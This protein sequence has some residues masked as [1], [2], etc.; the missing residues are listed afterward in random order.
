VL[1][2]GVGGSCRGWLPL[3]VPEFSRERRTLI[4]DYPGV[5]ESEAVDAPFTTAD[6]ADTT[7]ALLDALGV[8]RADVLGSFMGGMVAQELAL[9]HPERVERLALVGTYARPDA[10][11]VTLLRQWQDLA[12]MNAP[13]EMFVRERILWTL[14]DE[15]LEQK[16]LIESMVDF[17]SR[18]G[19][20]LTAA[21]FVRQCEACIG[22]DTLDRLRDVRQ[23]TLVLCGGNDQLTPPKFHRQLA[24]EIPNAQLV[25]LSY[26]GH[27]VMVESAE[28]FNRTVAQFLADER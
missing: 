2:V 25:T 18:D 24:D 26:G 23:R 7:V 14:Q 13:L 21:V 8:E 16:D 1:C 10:K 27:A 20:P 22:H 5:G 9:R 3:Q 11:R 17:H 28:S 19:A 6:L 15:T 4:F 12:R